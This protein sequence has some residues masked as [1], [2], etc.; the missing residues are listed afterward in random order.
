M[1]A[2]SQN[3]EYLALRSLSEAK[4]YEDGVVILEGDEGGQIY[5]VCPASLVRRKESQ[6]RQ[7]LADLD[8]VAWP[9]NRGQGAH[10]YYE[11][12]AIGSSVAGGM[13]GGHVIGGIWVHENLAKL[14]LKEGIGAVIEGR[15]SSLP[16]RP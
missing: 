12:L 16:K 14:G 2:D 13:G 15:R 5:V 4:S 3:I 9:V 8:V 11:R 6:L 7:L 10:I 1:I